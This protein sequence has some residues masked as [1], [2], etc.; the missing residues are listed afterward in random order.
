MTGFIIGILP[1]IL[2]VEAQKQEDIQINQQDIDKLV[3]AVVPQGDVSK[4]EAQKQS[5]QDYFINKMGIDV[6]LFY[7]IDD[8]YDTRFIKNRIY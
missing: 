5:L 3:I 4:F 8:T 1:E 2:K 6:E 7:P